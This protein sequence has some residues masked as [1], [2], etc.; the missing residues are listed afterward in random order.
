MLQGEGH[1]FKG[2]FDALSEYEKKSFLHLL[3]GLCPGLKNRVNF[4]IH[5]KL[6][7]CRAGCIRL[8]AVI[9]GTRGMRIFNTISL[10]VR[11]L[12]TRRCRDLKEWHQNID[13]E[14]RLDAGS[15][16]EIDLLCKK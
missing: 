9:A 12:N 7:A 6:V 2:G 3:Y 5:L 16:S 13:P 10:K 1:A 15:F 11:C 14:N 4:G 8:M